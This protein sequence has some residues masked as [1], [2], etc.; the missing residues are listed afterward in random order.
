MIL[1]CPYCNRPVDPGDINVAA[2]QARCAACG[3]AFAPSEV[4]PARS[5]DQSSRVTAPATDE[6]PRPERAPGYTKVRVYEDSQGVNIELPP[7]GFRWE[8]LFLGGFAVAWWSFL[9]LFISVTFG[10]SCIARHFDAPPMGAPKG[11]QMFLCCFLIPFFLAGFA[12][13]GAIVW[14]LLG[15]THLRLGNYECACRWHLMGLGRTVRAD[16]VAT[17]VRWSSRGFSRPD[18]KSDSSTDPPHIQLLLG[19]KE[20]QVGQHLSLQE[21]EW[22]YHEIKDALSRRR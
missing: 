6:P 3:A 21:Q 4:L 9:I 5:H 10:I 19:P 20:I 13:V 18:R 11:V 7:Q 12:M 17:S 1:K 8:M 2:D 22:L 15:V 16:P 14:P